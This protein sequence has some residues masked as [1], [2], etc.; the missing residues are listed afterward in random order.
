MS[1]APLFEQNARHTLF[2]AIF[3]EWSK[4]FNFIWTKMIFLKIFY[5][6][7]RRQVNIFEKVD[8]IADGCH[9]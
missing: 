2:T 5:T 4:D 1:F 6:Q 7:R 3:R 8:G 9:F